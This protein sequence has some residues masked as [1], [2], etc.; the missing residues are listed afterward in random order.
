MS[1]EIPN[2]ERTPLY[3]FFEMLPA[4]LSIGVPVTLIFL[5]LID[6]VYGAIFVIAFVVFALFR[7]V[8]GGIDAFR[9]YRRLRFAESIDW[10]ALNAE[11][12]EELR[13]GRFAPGVQLQADTPSMPEPFAS[14]HQRFLEDIARNPGRHPLPSE[15]LHAVIVTAYNEPYEV[16]APSLRSLVASTFDHDRLVVV[17]AYEERGGDQIRETIVRLANE[18]EGH[19]SALLT[20]EHPAGLPD[21]IPGKGGNLTYAGH[22]LQ[23]WLDEQN[24]DSD[25]VLVTSLDCDNR[26]HPSY[27]DYVS[28]EFVRSGGN[29]RLSFQPISLFVN[30]VWH[31]PAPTRVIA[32]GNSLWNLISTVRP[33]SLRNFASHTQPMTALIQMNFWSKRT[34][35][36]DGHQFWRSYFFFR[37][38]YRAVAIHVPI[39]QDAVLA[40][41]MKRT[42][43]AQFKQLSRWS[44]GASDIPYVASHL[45]S[46]KR[47]A[48]FGRTARELLIL[49]D[50]HVTLA[51]M[52]PM[53]TFGA[54]VPLLV[55]RASHA[56]LT[57]AA[58]AQNFGIP[59]LLAPF[60]KE[61]GFISTAL[62]N[63]LIHSPAQPLVGT[64]PDVIGTIQR[65]ALVG[66]L[67]TIILTFLTIPPRPVEYGPG[68]TVGMLAQWIL[69]PITLMCYNTASAIF[70]QVRLFFGA[71]REQFDVTEKKASPLATVT[72]SIGIID[73]HDRDESS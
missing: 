73:P 22:K 70:S 16:I 38:D 52:A 66:V 5:S 28:Y 63:P 62:M 37:G 18:F 35:V 25:R 7:A 9:G 56:D 59:G 17:L 31:A 45:F 4:I 68:R 6:P 13:L 2:G 20:V 11:V 12:E 29:Q 23:E 15:L 53:L 44:Y 26:V 33:L 54:W 43:I 69:L 58:F 51:A 8:R 55:A 36:E 41:T 71:Y 48:P 21:E 67:V 34:I 60:F 46:P 10:G 32:A 61:P 40:D 47:S 65:F 30:N 27:F 42:L 50:S 49:I 57:S 64:L 3:R 24:I 1:I 72:G 19:F 14:K 39:Y